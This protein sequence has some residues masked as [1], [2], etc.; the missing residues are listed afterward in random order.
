MI[1]YPAMDFLEGKCVRLY[2]GQRDTAKVYDFSP[3]KWAKD[4]EAAG[5]K[6]LHLVDLD[7]AFTGNGMN[8]ASLLAIRKAVSLPIEIG[9]GIRSREQAAYWINN[10]FQVVLGTLLTEDL[11]LVK[12]L[13]EE[14]PNQIVAGIDCLDMKVKTKGWVSDSGLDA[15][16]FVKQLKQ[17]GLKRFVFTDIS[18]DGTLAGPNLKALVQLQAIGDVEIIASGGVSSKNDLEALKSLN[19]YG[20][21]VGKAL[22]GG[23]LSPEDALEACDAK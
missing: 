12:A 13:V 11:A 4:W 21:I 6:A 23:S 19:L 2:Q 20:A 16:D 14:Y 5:A 22:L 9:G 15:V 17:L 3:E 18:K 7:G 10:G 8:N 1:L